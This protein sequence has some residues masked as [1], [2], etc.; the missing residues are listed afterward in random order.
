MGLKGECGRT[1]GEGNGHCCKQPVTECQGKQ[2]ENPGLLC[3]PVGLEHCRAQWLQQQSLLV[4]DIHTKGLCSAVKLGWIWG[5]FR[6]KVVPN[7]EAG[8]EGCS[9]LLWFRVSLS[10]LYPLQRV[11][12][13]GYSAL[14]AQ[15]LETSREEAKGSEGHICAEYFS[16]QPWPFDLKCVTC[17]MPIP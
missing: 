12:R 1:A 10:G 11:S 17:N 9:F 6:T 5:G 14:S 3:S 7:S 8:A 2:P 13:K 16:M 15:P 4:E